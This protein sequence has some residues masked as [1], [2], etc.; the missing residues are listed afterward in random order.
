MNKLASEVK[1][2]PALYATIDIIPLIAA[3]SLRIL[4]FQYLKA[5]SLSKLPLAFLDLLNF[6]VKVDDLW[7]LGW[8]ELEF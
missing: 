7:C 5:A 4:F 6:G 1:C 3:F 8:L 2:L